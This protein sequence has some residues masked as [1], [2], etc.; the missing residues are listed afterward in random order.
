MV[1]LKNT[2][3]ILFD[4]VCNLCNKS[5]NF[6][7]KHDKKKQFLFAP[8]QSDAATKILLQLNRKSFK[9]LNSIVLIYDKNIYTK[10]TASLYI[11]RKLSAPVKLL[12]VFII[13][14]KPI[15]DSVYD[16]IAK[17]RYKWFGKKNKC[18][19]PSKEVADRFL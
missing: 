12:Y 15:R 10:S 18:M 6:I 4:G 13:I 3:V 9:N 1:L 19:I 16:F 17:N 11:I 2:P 5:V 8:L 14:P 7:L